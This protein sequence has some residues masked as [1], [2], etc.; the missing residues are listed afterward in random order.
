[1]SPASGAA[2]PPAPKTSGDHISAYCVLDGYD[3]RLTL[4]RHRTA[5]SLGRASRSIS[6][7][8]FSYPLSRSWIARVEPA[9]GLSGVSDPFVLRIGVMY[10]INSVARLAP[11]F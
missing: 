4:F 11:A 6:A 1:M 10:S 3:I 7:H 9:F 5:V 2:R 8:A